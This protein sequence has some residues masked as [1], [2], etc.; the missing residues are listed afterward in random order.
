ML[1]MLTEYTT[2]DYAR[3]FSSDLWYWISDMVQSMH[4]IKAFVA[5][6]R[7]DLVANCD[8]VRSYAGYTHH[9]G[10]CS[11]EAG[12][13]RDL[14]CTRFRK[15]QK[16]LEVCMVVRSQCVMCKHQTRVC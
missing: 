7:A 10:F 9:D 8:W 4:R 14:D 13:D 6:Y 2:N 12:A 1:G 5:D 16:Q 15:Y 11:A 3:R